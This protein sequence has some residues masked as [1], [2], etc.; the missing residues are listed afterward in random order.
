[1]T[2]VGRRGWVA[3]EM[4]WWGPLGGGKD[5]GRERNTLGINI[6]VVLDNNVCFFF[7]P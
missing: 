7:T 4:G 5:E 3:R 1:M 6:R 2:G